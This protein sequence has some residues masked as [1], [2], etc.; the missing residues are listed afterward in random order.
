M[1][2]GLIQVGL[3]VNF[4]QAVLKPGYGIRDKKEKDLRPSIDAS[5]FN[6]LIDQ[7]LGNRFF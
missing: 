4:D 1:A 2:R 5:M 6:H 3:L 7:F